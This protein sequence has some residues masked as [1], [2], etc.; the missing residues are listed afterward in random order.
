MRDDCYLSFISIHLTNH[1]LFDWLID[2]HMAVL[3][4]YIAQH[5]SCPSYHVWTVPAIEWS[6][7]IRHYCVCSLLAPEEKWHPHLAV[8][9]VSTYTHRYTLV[10]ATTRKLVITMIQTVIVI[11][12][13]L[14]TMFT[15]IILT[16]SKSVTWRE[17]DYHFSDHEP[18]DDNDK[19]YWD[20]DIMEAYIASAAVCRCFF[21]SQW[22]ASWCSCTCHFQW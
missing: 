11:F 6:Q 8:G 12:M 9:I 17:S 10:E 1:F 2:S 7:I 22:H 15:M 13:V 20:R 14:V 16:R 4:K 5:I 3:R 19:D 21:S 18:D